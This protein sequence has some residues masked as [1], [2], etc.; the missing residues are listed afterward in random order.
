MDSEVREKALAAI[1]W[2]Q[3]ASGIPGGKRWEYKLIPDDGIEAAN[4]FGFTM[5]QSYRFEER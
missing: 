1:S 3:I 5:S 2:C 4:D